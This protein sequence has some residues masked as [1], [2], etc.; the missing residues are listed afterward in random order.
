MQWHHDSTNAEYKANAEF[1]QNLILPYNQR[2]LMGRIQGGDWS[3]KK[4]AAILEE[5]EKF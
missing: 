3:E 4:M 5:V 2:D 1:G